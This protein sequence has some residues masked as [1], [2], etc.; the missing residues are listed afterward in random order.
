MLVRFAALFAV[1][2]PVLERSRLIVKPLQL[3]A[4]SKR[5]NAVSLRLLLDPKPSHRPQ[6]GKS[7]VDYRLCSSVEIYIVNLNAHSPLAHSKLQDAARRDAAEVVRG[8]QLAQDI[9]SQI[10]VSER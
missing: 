3:R 10:D 1:F 4:Q 6:S 5:Q 8:T 2:I 9:L 7:S